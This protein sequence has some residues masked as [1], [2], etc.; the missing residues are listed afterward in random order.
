MNREISNRGETLIEVVL[1]VAL[2]SLTILMSASLFFSAIKTTEKN[3]E[4]DMKRNEL[5]NAA[6]KKEHST[7]QNGTFRFTLDGGGT[8]AQDVTLWVTKLPDT[9]SVY[10]YSIR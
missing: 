4:T 9:A 5:L 8:V 3:F 1:S 6:V 2:F 7:P 10:Q